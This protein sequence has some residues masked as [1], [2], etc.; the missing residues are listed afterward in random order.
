MRLAPSHPARSPLSGVERRVRLSGMAGL[1]LALR[2]AGRAE[3]HTQVAGQ[4]LEHAGGQPA[5]RLLVDRC[6]GWHVIRHGSPRNAVADDV[7]QAVKQRPERVQPP[8]GILP[9]Q[10]HV[11]RNQRSFFIEDIG[12]VWLADSLHALH[13]KVLPQRAI[14]PFRPAPMPKPI[15]RIEIITGRERRRRYSA[16][17][18]FRW[19]SRPCSQAE[20]SPPSP[21]STASRRA[22]C[23]NVRG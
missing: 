22:C 11:G 9:R 6:P 21:G 14:T 20:R 7:T 5:L 19:S 12:W 17:R 16:R 23:S 10:D 1:S 2:P 4:G 13:Q 8:T 3:D 15:E 18:K